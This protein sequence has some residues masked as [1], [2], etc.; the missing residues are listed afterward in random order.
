MKA[1]AKDFLLGTATAAHQVEGNNVHSDSWVMEHMR[2][3]TYEEPS[4]DAVD[5]YKES[6]W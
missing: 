3:T 5:H 1:F 4:L 6:I 2:Y